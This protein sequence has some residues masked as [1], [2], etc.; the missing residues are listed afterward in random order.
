MGGAGVRIRLVFFFKVA[1][2]LFKR[3]LWSLIGKVF[4]FHSFIKSISISVIVSLLFRSVDKIEF[5]YIMILPY[6]YYM[7]ICSTYLELAVRREK[8]GQSS[9]KCSD[10]GDTSQFVMEQFAYD[11]CPD[12]TVYMSYAS[13]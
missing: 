13:S 8:E 3:G 5:W 11:I 1:D 4:L 10:A 7:N 9:G 2:W 12:M 6:M